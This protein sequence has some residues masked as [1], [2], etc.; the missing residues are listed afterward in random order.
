MNLAR[1]EFLRTTAGATGGLLALPI[2]TQPT[3][4]PLPSRLIP[5]DKG[6]SAETLGVLKA[7]GERRIYRGAQRFA[8][9]MPIGGICAGQ[10]YLLGDGTLGGWHI[11]GQ[12]NSTGYGSEN[13]KA[14]RPARELEQGFSIRVKDDAGKE[15]RAVLADSENGG[16]YDRVEFVGE[17]PVA[18]VRYKGTREGL[19][20]VVVALRAF[21]PF[22]PLNAKDSAL[23]C[24]VME[25]TVENRSQG[26]VKIVLNGW[27]ENGVERGGAE[28]EGPVSRRN[29]VVREGGL[30]AVVMSAAAV[31]AVGA[32][33]PER[34]LWDF[35]GGNYEGWTVEGEAFGKTPSAGAEKNQQAVTGFTGKGLVNSFRPAADTAAGDKP[36]GKMTSGEFEIDRRYL[37]FRIG[38]GGHKGRTC[39]N[40]LVDSKV[41][42]TSTGKNDE[43]LEQR[44]WDISDLAGRKA[45]LEIVDAAT[46]PWGHI[47]VDE[48][49]LVDAV[50]EGLARGRGSSPTS[51]TM[52]LALLGG[53]G[54][55][56]SDRARFEKAGDPNDDFDAGLP[57]PP[58]ESEG[59][60]PVGLVIARLKLQT[61]E[62]KTIRFVI[63]WHFPNLHT[64][65]GQM[66]SNWFKDAT[67]VVRYIATNYARLRDQTELFRKTCY[68]DTTLPSWLVS[69]LMM[70]V[71][72]LATGTSQ[73]WKNGRF[74]GWE[75][76]GCC[77][78]TCTHV[79][80]Y[81]HAEA[82]LFPE[83]ARS[84]RVMQDLGSA[85]EEKT[86]RVAFRG[87][88]HGGSEY[89]ADGQ[90]GTV[91]KCY[92]E[93][94]CSADDAFLKAN[95][96]KIKRA[97]D[98]LVQQDSVG[99]G[100]AKVEPD[101]VLE[102]AQPNTYDIDF[103]GP[104]TFCGS[105]YLAALLAG[106]EMASRMGDDALAARYRSIY[107][108]G[109]E[110]TE[111][112]L[113]KNGYFIQRVPGGAADRFQY[114][115]GCLSDQLFGQTWARMVGLG[116][117]YDPEKIVSALKSIYKHNWSPEV[118]RYSAQWPPERRFAEAREGG[119]FVCT[120]PRGGRPAEPVR[121]RD[122]V[123]TGIEYQV[124]ACMMAEGLV[125]DALVLIKAI[126]ER[127]DGT[128]HNPWN[129]VECGDHYARAMA[130]YGVLQ[131]AM[132]FE[133]DGPRG[134]IG[135]APRLTPNDFAAFFS[136]AEGWGLLR[137]VREDGRQVNTVEV[138]WGKLAAREFAAVLPHAPHPVL[139]WEVS[140]GPASDPG[141]VRPGLKVRVE[142]SGPFRTPAGIQTR[143]RSEN[144]RTV[145]VL[146]EPVIIQAGESL[147]VRWEW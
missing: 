54:K 32:G 121:Y 101:G 2:I 84:T 141:G 116:T 94:L 70:P 10:L 38:G 17:F 37:A 72:T 6:I 106:A 123:W 48:I 127:Y 120:W 77:D 7:R 130:S 22:C 110:W 88:V 27:L 50:P 74:W 9:G 86:G 122:E 135:M 35:E 65:Q 59:A 71:S 47:N 92:R 129:E 145:A 80:N 16:D 1:R 60:P 126:D 36:T 112:N 138:K 31:R 91:L 15:S 139:P 68:D 87:E 111:Q 14:H 45:R 26:K 78:G 40:L 43:R 132:G 56:F 29:E 136:G 44:L 99:G 105:L 107:S 24:T 61:G 39:M 98:F 73:W 114:G 18:E 83:L 11:D 119:L 147:T 62:R 131:A 79:W 75:G 89:A 137:Q 53:E 51:G 102:N 118:G 128:L 124:A 67:E 34:M 143:I 69:R 33:R 103:V 142:T 20:P 82:R 30:T 66:Y 63:A 96:E 113:Y 41:V 19:P 3:A 108:K 42:R 12:R 117:V 104:N 64:G 85:F 23:P 90:A 100:G 52:C 8:I 93:H 81:S 109:R 4:K 46:G 55:A 95:W 21:S 144:G 5:E 58:A 28:D 134:V 49:R 125:D 97:L 140:R 13:Y 133:Y 76:V 115:D 25:F 57:G 146:P